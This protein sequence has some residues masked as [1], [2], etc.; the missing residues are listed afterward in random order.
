MHAMRRTGLWWIAAQQNVIA[1]DWDSYPCPTGHLPCALTNR[2]ITPTIAGEGGKALM[3]IDLVKCKCFYIAW[4]TC[5]PYYKH[6]T[7]WPKLGLQEPDGYRFK[8]SLQWR[9]ELWGTFTLLPTCTHARL[10]LQ[11]FLTHQQM[12]PRKR[13][14]CWTDQPSQHQASTVHA[15]EA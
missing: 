9:I 15:V 11:L 12:L 2:A 14:I 1:C 13:T 8:V 6:I 3:L 10:Q 7:V 4:F 5:N